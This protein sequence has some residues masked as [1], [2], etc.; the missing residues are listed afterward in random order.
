MDNA[1]FMDCSNSA[2]LLY[3]SKFEVRPSGHKNEYL[4]VAV[5]FK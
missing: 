2:T 3:D 5:G 4:N 1:V